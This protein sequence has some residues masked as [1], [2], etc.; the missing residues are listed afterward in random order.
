M[1]YSAAVT[2]L[3]HTLCLCTIREHS[4]LFERHL[5]ADVQTLNFHSDYSYTVKYAHSADCID[6]GQ[7]IIEY[8]EISR[9]GGWEP[10]MTPGSLSAAKVTHGMCV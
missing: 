8:T 2:S 5:V 6:S 3:A 9:E 7:W 4:E 10:G 1:K